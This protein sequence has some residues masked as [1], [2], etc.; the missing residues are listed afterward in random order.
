MENKEPI[1]F[2]IKSGAPVKN[3]IKI[4]NQLSKANRTVIFTNDNTLSIASII[5]MSGVKHRIIE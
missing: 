2:H 4:M 5:Y 1:K 3:M